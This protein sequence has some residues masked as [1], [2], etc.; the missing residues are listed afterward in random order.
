M[1]SEEEKLRDEVIEMAK[2]A[3][4]D[5]VQ[6]FV[7]T[8]LGQVLEA[9]GQEVADAK[10]EGRELKPYDIARFCLQ[11]FKSQTSNGDNG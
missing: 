9:A 7:Q 1:K 10:A 4:H 6:E 5:R 8:P 11:A 3:V 2:E